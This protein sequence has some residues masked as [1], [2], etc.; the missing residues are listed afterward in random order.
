MTLVL[1]NARLADGRLVDLAMAAGTIT[2]VTPSTGG[3]AAIDD[4]PGSAAEVEDLGGLLVLPA[5]VEPHAHLDKALTAEL[6][7]NPTGDLLGAIDAWNRADDAG[8]LD[9]DGT[10]ARAT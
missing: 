1:R 7:P 3:A 4:D 9:H 6:A 5:A 10:V 2:A 8:L